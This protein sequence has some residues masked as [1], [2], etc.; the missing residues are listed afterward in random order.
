MKILNKIICFFRNHKPI[1]C[2][3]NHKHNYVYDFNYKCDRC[4]K[5]L[6]LPQLTKEYTDSLLIQLEQKYEE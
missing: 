5:S 6:G 2:K 3:H 4:G 1:S